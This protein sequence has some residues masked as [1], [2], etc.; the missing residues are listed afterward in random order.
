MKKKVKKTGISDNKSTSLTLD[1]SAKKE[2]Q[3]KFA[4]KADLLRYFGFG[5]IADIVEEEE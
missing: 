3:R 2:L 4:D 1:K 5:E